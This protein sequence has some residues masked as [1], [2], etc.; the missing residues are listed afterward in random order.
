[1]GFFFFGM[2][3]LVYKELEGALSF[4]SVQ[5]IFFPTL[6]VSSQ[7]KWC[8]GHELAGGDGNV[9]VYLLAVL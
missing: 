1:M 2:F 9:T 5:G 7:K 8:T 6:L 4:Q 3:S